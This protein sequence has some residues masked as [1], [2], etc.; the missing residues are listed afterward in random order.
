MED[1]CHE[2]ELILRQKLAL[3]LIEKTPAQVSQL[4]KFKLERDLKKSEII[5]FLVDYNPNSVWKTKMVE[6]AKELPFAGQIR[7]V[8]GGLAMW[9]QGLKRLIQS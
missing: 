6:K 3:K 2:M 4:K 1:L 7:I 9:D 5:L 8:D